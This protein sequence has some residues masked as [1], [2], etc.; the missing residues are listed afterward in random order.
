MAHARSA[1]LRDTKRPRRSRR[2]NG[3]NENFIEIKKSRDPD[4]PLSS[5][6]I[7][8]VGSRPFASRPSVFSL[9]VKCIFRLS[10]VSPYLVGLITAPS[11]PCSLSLFPRLIFAPVAN[12]NHNGAPDVS[13][14][15]GRYRVRV[16]RRECRGSKISRLLSA[17]RAVIA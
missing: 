13:Q 10:R 8:L 2:E 1:S 15:A 4:S 7:H 16:F 3:R 12:G 5:F 17:P 11:Y 9:L 14:N 6:L